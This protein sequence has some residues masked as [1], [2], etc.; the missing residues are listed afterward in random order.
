[1]I[2]ELSKEKI[3]VYI[4]STY[5]NIKIYP[6]LQLL[7][8]NKTLKKFKKKKLCVL[9]YDI[10]KEDIGNRE[11]IVSSKIRLQLK[12]HCDNLKRWALAG[13]QWLTPV[14]PATQETEIRRNTAQS[15][16]GK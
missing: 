13:H 3:Y 15:Q 11:G 10:K 1:L 16:L 12:L 9:A 5:V 14:I 6:P 8:V 7:Y 2:W 4:L